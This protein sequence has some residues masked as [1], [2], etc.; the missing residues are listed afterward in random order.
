MIIK[1]NV[2]TCDIT[3][4]NYGKYVEGAAALARGATGRWCAVLWFGPE[5]IADNDL[6]IISR[7]EAVKRVEA[8]G[9]RVDF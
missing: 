8:L 9:D 3:D 4:R 5:Y 7:E 6:K 2:S 1:A